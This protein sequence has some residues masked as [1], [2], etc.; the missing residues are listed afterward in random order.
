MEFRYAVP[1]MAKHLIT[2][3]QPSIP[4]GFHFHYDAGDQLHA[5]SAHLVIEVDRTP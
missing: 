2:L 4:D 5:G 1:P 3:A